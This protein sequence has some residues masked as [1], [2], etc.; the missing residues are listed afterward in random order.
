MLFR[1]LWPCLFAVWG[2]AMDA[3]DAETDVGDATN[4]TGTDTGEVLSSRSDCAYEVRRLADDVEL[5]ACASAPVSPRIDVDLAV[6]NDP[7][8]E[9][10][11]RLHAC[12]WHT[13]TATSKTMLVACP[14]ESHVVSGGCMSQTPMLVS[15]PWENDT[16][17]DLPERGERY[18]HV[19]DAN[20]WMCIYEGSPPS[21]QSATALC[22]E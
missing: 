17:G 10:G 13:F 20:G 3:A 8:L 15:A 2:C 11:K 5:Y 4:E 16:L 21:G 22:C 12:T 19:S 1:S 18:Q 9:P 14:A 6:D 7:V